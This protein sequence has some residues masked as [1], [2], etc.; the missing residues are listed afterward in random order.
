[1]TTTESAADRKVGARFGYLGW[2]GHGNLGDDAIREAI[3]SR[4]P[5]ASMTPM[6]TAPLESARTFVR[7]HHAMPGARV[8]IGGGT[9]IGRANSATA[10]TSG[11]PPLPRCAG[12]HAQPRGGGSGIRRT[13]FL[14]RL[15]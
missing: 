10:R 1:M 2:G 4:V 6:P 14:L 15:R 5:G 13:P 7:R 3:E 11:P 9:V 12:R 8:L